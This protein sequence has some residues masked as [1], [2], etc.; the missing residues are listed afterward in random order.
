MRK[1]DGPYLRQSGP[2]FIDVNGVTQRP[3]A[4]MHPCMHPGCLQEGSRGFGVN[5]RRGISGTWFCFD[6]H[7][8]GEALLTPK[9]QSAPVETGA[10]TNEHQT[11]SDLFGD[12]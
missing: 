11:S 7:L 1:P 8:D 2:E 9:A 5:L 4:F 6:H 10:P 12:P 3:K